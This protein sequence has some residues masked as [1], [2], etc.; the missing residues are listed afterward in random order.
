MN[1]RNKG[2]P[3]P[4]LQQRGFPL[5]NWTRNRNLVGGERRNNRWPNAAEPISDSWPPPF[6]KDILFSSKL[7]TGIFED[8][9]AMSL[10]PACRLFGYQE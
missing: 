2:M 4:P 5:P 9:A 6:E 8:E 1:E 10:L 3:L 7:A